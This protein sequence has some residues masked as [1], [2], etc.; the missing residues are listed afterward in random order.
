MNKKSDEFAKRLLSAFRIEAEEHLKN[1]TSGLIELE[2]GPEQ[3]AKTEVIETVFR[4]A[5]SLKGAARAVNLTDIEKIC[6]SLEGVF[7]SLKRNEIHLGPFM[8]DTLHRAVDI[9][10]ELNIPDGSAVDKAGISIIIENI[11]KIQKGQTE[12]V[13]TQPEPKVIPAGEPV[14]REKQ[15]FSDTIRISAE[16]MDA[17]LRQGEEMF[18]LKLM[19]NQNLEDIDDL[20]RMFGTWY[21]QWSAIYP[22]MCEFRRLQEKGGRQ[23]E[24]E[25]IYN[26]RNYKLFEFIDTTHENMKTLENRLIEF[27]RAGYR[28]RYA[29]GLMVDNLLGE[30]KAI[31]MLPFSTLLE[32][33]PKFVRDLSRDQGK[34][35]ELVISGEEIEIDRRILEE[36]KVVFIHLLRNAIDHGIEK[37]E[38]RLQNK[39]AS[40]GK[41]KITVSR[42][43]GNKVNILL[44]DD[45]AGIDMQ[46]LKGVLMKKGIVPPEDAERLTEQDILAIVFQS[47]V[48]T[49]PIIT[50]ISGRGLGLA[51][52]REKI[53]KLGGQIVLETHRHTGTSLSITLPLTLITFRG[54]LVNVAEREFIVPTINVEKAVRV[55][56]DEIKTV[57]NRDTL[58]LN[59]VT[60]PL[61]K[62]ANILGLEEKNGNAA[63][64]TVLVLTSQGKR[65]GFVVNE[66]LGEQ[67]VLI[68]GLS[69]PLVRVRNIA[70][71]TILGSGKVAPVLNVSDLIKS[72]TKHAASPLKTEIAHEKEKK[73]IL[74]VEDSITSRMLIK[75]ILETF[76][77]HVKTAVDGV[78]AVMQLKTEKFD[79]VVSDVDMPRMNGFD[80]T[81]KIRSD[82]KFSELPVILV[83]ALES[84]AD[85]ERGI[86]VGANAYIVKSSFDQVNLLEI[87]GRLI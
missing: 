85:R 4:E 27:R 66:V 80:L 71:A 73:S 82:K 56:G 26:H 1:I 10:G 49:S 22:T 67:E 3:Q 34:D 8:F 23:D 64:M 19:A 81:A 75:N 62:L 29:T 46:V 28:Q 2:K 37:P 51:I 41:I 70:G 44:S 78:D 54:L 52:A 39:K 24:K 35:I 38:I 53:E 86:D 31:L 25:G 61:S 50:D 65:I 6:Q 77:Y 63:T 83:T 72:A 18:A 74:V 69:Q 43:E 68:K 32:T 36:M 7:S 84:R 13:K 57:E 5:H 40:R 42:M 33:F 12:A 20:I 58:S 76:G 14:R 87:V 9:L 30:M 15:Q 55:S 16:K 59:G 60:L 17:L 79:L 48:S 47:G 21:K 11:D 45:G